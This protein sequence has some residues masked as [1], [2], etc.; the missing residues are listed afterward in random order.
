MSNLEVLET[1]PFACESN[2]NAI[3]RRLLSQDALKF[4]KKIT[5]EMGDEAHWTLNEIVKLASNQYE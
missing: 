4:Q 2:C 5:A 3:K 1:A